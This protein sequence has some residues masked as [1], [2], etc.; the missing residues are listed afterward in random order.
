MKSN[1]CFSFFHF[2]L[3][4]STSSATKWS[5]STSTPFLIMPTSSRDPLWMDECPHSLITSISLLGHTR[6]FSCRELHLDPL[7]GSFRKTLYLIL[8]LGQKK[9]VLRKREQTSAPGG[10]A[11]QVDTENLTQMPS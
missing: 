9:T 7:G 3:R 1:S 4:S 6:T 5:R 11:A 8:R 2:L 10:R